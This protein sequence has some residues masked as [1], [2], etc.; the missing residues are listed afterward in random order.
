MK[1]REFI[2]FLG[3]AAAWPIAVSPERPGNPGR[4][5]AQ[6]GRPSGPAECPLLGQGEMRNS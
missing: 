2:T 1:R 5:L 3:S 4:L 6:S